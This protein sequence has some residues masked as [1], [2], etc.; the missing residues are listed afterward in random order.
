MHYCFKMENQ[1]LVSV[2]MPAYNQAQYIHEAIDSVVNQT[3]KN[4]E[5]IIV[6]DGSP[7][8]VADIVKDYTCK[9]KRIKFYH[10]ENHGVSAAR[11]YAV[12]QSHGEFIIPLDA[13]D[14]IGE[15][16]LQKSINRFI[17]HPETDLVYCQ[18]MRFGDMT[19]SDPIKYKG[20]KELLIENSIF[21]SCIYK[22]KDFDRIGG[23][24]EN[25]KLALED[26]EFLIR[27]LSPSSVVFQIP[28][29]MFH[30]RIKN[31]SR[32]SVTFNNLLPIKLIYSKHQDLYHKILGSPIELY[33]EGLSYKR[34]Y[35]NQWHKKFWYKYIVKKHLD[36]YTD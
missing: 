31:D 19:S 32:N 15:E 22:R 2:I 13:D 4:W 21:N 12:S 3:Y 18:W 7:D 27:L 35:Y 24:D 25:F 30:Y 29:I 9:D 10:T 5:L 8:N 26:W 1:P 33:M 17:L 23:Y 28:D 20:Y 6:D 11:N 16:Y 36:C 34:K 14:W